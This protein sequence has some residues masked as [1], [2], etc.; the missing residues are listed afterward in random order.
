MKG[1]ASLETLTK[2]LGEPATCIRRLAPAIVNENIPSVG[3]RVANNLRF[4]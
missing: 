2:S 1:A 3:R 4:R